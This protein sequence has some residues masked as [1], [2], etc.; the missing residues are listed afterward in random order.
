LNL[1]NFETNPGVRLGLPLHMTFVVLTLSICSYCRWIP[2]PLPVTR[3][4]EH[5]KESASTY[6][7][8][9]TRVIFLQSHF[10]FIYF[11]FFC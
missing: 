3:T 2:P 7:A 5:E 11:F 8:G 9:R 10:W 4:Q 6:A 1:A